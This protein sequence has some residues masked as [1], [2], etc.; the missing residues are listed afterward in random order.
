MVEKE[1]EKNMKNSRGSVIVEFALVLPI[2]CFLL[3]GGIDL[4]GA[5]TTVGQVSYIAE[6]SARCEALQN[7]AC[8]VN[9]NGQNQ[10]TSYAQQL[11]A[12]MQIRNYTDLT[13]TQNS[14]AHCS[15]VTVSYTYQSLFHFLPQIA[16]RRTAQ[17]TR[18]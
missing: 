17:F 10:A 1:W 9:I 15:S 14:C 11:A 5:Y 18:S 3:L 16:I 8:G 4:I 7:P 13:V 6:E 2:L 12:G